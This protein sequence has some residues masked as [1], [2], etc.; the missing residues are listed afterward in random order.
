MEARAPPLP[1]RLAQARAMS[2]TRQYTLENSNH[3]RAARARDAQERLSQAGA[4][5]SHEGRGGRSRNQLCMQAVHDTLVRLWESKPGFPPMNY[6]LHDCSAEREALTILLRCASRY[7]E[8]GLGKYR[9]FLSA[10]YTI[11]RT[12]RGWHISE[13]NSDLRR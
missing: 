1:D 2:E 10:R 3:L 4:N 7:P 8:H 13:I 12:R 5:R 11:W 9:R 6:S